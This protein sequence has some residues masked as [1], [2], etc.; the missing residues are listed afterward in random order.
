MQPTPNRS[1]SRANDQLVRDWLAHLRERRLQGNTLYSYESVGLALLTAFGAKPISTLTSRQLQTFL[2]RPRAGR[3]RGGEAKSSTLARELAVLRNLY[4]WLV[5]TGDLHRSPIDLMA[6]PKVSNTLPKAIA[7]DLWLK[8][9][10]SPLDDGSRV[11]LGL[12]YFGG[13]RRAE[14]TSL[15]VHNIDLAARRIVR[16]RR[17]GGGDDYVAFGSI[18]DVIEERLPHVL[19]QGGTASVLEPMERLVDARTP[20]QSLLPWD[21][22]PASQVA[23]RRHALGEGQIDPQ[24]VNMRFRTWLRRAGIR[25]D[26]FTPHALR[27]SAVTN[28][29]RA[30]VP[31]ALVS[32]LVNHANIQTTMRYAK[33]GQDE[34]EEWLRLNRHG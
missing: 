8:L 5:A 6:A 28:L 32:K 20:D 16:F 19:G 10:G 18:L 23:R 21:F 22:V 7:D 33:L 11:V 31:I 26:A 14:I 2:G 12:G 1:I 30:G 24:R 17:K 15:R 27:H 25:E 4:A 13:L 29:L 34:L 3:A 9:W